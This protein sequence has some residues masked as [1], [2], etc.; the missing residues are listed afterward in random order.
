MPP[1]F[2]KK[3]KDT[4]GK[5]VG[6]LCSNPSCRVLTSGP[7]SESGKA[8]IIGEA[9]H[10]FGANPCSARFD[11]DMTDGG[12]AEIANA[13]WLCR[14]CHKLVDDDSRHFPAELLQVPA[15]LDEGIDQAERSGDK[16]T[17]ISHTI[18]FALPDNWND[19]IDR[20]LKRIEQ[21]YF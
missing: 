17:V 8:S 4:L 5:R 16:L 9:V 1:E 20:E 19:R 6:M 11:E 14:N 10:I 7:S 2:S 13:I 3:T 15:V 21:T 12:C 18:E